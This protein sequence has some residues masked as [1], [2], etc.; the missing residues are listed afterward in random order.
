[1]L[2]FLFP[3]DYCTK[4]YIRLGKFS[5]YFFNCL[6]NDTLIRSVSPLHFVISIVPTLLITF[7]TLECSTYVSEM[8]SIFAPEIEAYRQSYEI[9]P[10]LLQFDVPK[11]TFTVLLE[12]FALL[13]FSSLTSFN[14]V[15]S[16]ISSSCSSLC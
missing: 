6:G 15:L 16:W 12:L 3:W 13:V 4:S 8:F 7:S 11:T 14:D 2:T 9:L 5:F 10:S 1:M